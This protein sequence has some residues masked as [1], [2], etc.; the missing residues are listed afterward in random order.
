M[1]LAQGGVDI[2]LLSANC[3][4]RGF[5]WSINAGVKLFMSGCC[6]NVS[7]LEAL[8][9]IFECIRCYYLALAFRGADSFEFNLLSK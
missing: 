6:G 7:A 2:E 4:L 9:G 8:I 5:K 1:L 3:I